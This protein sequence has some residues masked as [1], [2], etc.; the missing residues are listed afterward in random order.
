MNGLYHFEAIA[1]TD[2]KTKCSIWAYAV[3]ALQ[4]VGLYVVLRLSEGI[5]ATQHSWPEWLAE[6]NFQGGL[7]SF[8]KV[9]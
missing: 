6:N 3:S 1:A 5:R 2:L 9:I 8:Y 7:V 4:K